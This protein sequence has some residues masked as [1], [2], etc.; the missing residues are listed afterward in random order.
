[1]PP[2]HCFACFATVQEELQALAENDP[3]RVTWQKQRDEARERKRM[4]E[5]KRY[6]DNLK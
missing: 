6:A 5:Q 1:M 2:F 3:R 4:E